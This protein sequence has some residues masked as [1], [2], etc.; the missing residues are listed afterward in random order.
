MYEDAE[1][2]KKTNAEK[3]IHFDKL[4]DTPKEE[5]FVNKKRDKFVLQRFSREYDE[6]CQEHNLD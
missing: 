6:A 1:K 5:A 4:V 3:K 2:R